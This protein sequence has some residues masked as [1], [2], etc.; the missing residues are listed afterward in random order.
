MVQKRI[1][2]HT[3]MSTPIPIHLGAFLKMLRDRHGIAQA[4]VLQHLP[5]WQQSAY[6]KVEKDTRAPTFDQLVPIYSALAQAGVQLS[7]QDRQQF[8]LLARRKIE[9]RKTRHERKADADWE[10]L[11]L[12]LAG[13]DQQPAE[14][15]NP[16]PTHASRLSRPRLVES[17]HL[18]GREEWIAS[19][20]ARL[21]DPLQKLLILQG[22]VG[23]GKSSELHRLANHFLQNISWYHVV[24]CELPSLEQ[25]VIGVD[26]A[27][28]LLLS[29]ILEVIGSPYASMP[30]AS[31]AA[32]VKYV[33][34]CLSRT[35][36]P[37][38]ILLDNAEQLLDEYGELAPVSK[39]FLTKFVQTGHRASLILATKEW[40][41]SF[42]EETQLVMS[43]TIPV[44]SKE[45][46]SQLFHRLG[47]QGIPDEHLGRVVEAVGGIPLCL[48]WVAKLVQE[49]M[50]HNDWDDFEEEADSEVMLTQLLE[51]DSLFGGPVARRLQPLLERVVK[52]LSGE[53]SSAL[54]ELAVSP[55]PLGSPALKAL[56]HDPS[57]LKELR[58]AS[59]LVAY[60]KRV[61]LLPMVAASMRS[62]MSAEQVRHAEERLIGAFTQWL[63]VGISSMRE[64]GIAVTELVC[65]LLHR[66]RL[67]AAAELILYYGWLSR[68]VGQILRLAQFVQQILSERPWE[69]TPE[70]EVEIESGGI[71]LHYYLSSYLGVHIDVSERA[72]AY[73]RILAHVI[74]G[75]VTVEPLMEV[76]LMDQIMLH[77]LYED[78]FEEAQRLYTD[79]F[80]RLEP[81]LSANAELHATLLSKQATMCSKRSNYAKM[82]GQNDE[83][84]RLREETIAIY[85]RCLNLLQIAEQQK[86]VTLLRQ[87]TLK[88]KRAT[89]LNNLAYQLNNSGRYE[90]ALKLIEQCIELK[91]Q[92]FAERDSLPAAYNEKSQLLA[93]LGQ[94]Q[95]A[96][97][98]DQLAREEVQRCAEAGDA[99]SQEE[100]WFYQVDQGR[101]YLLLGRVDEAEYLL[102]EAEPHIHPQRKVYRTIARDA[103][104][105]IEQWRAASQNAHYQIDWRWIKR[106]RQLGAYDSLWWWAQTGSFTEEEQRQWDQ[107]YTPNPDEDTK[108]QLAGLIVQSRQREL[109]AAITEG[110]EPYLHYP[111]L[112]IEAVRRRIAGMLVLDEEIIEQE[113]N[114]IVR[115]LYHG[116]IEDEVC[117]LRMIEATY[118]RSNDRF[119]KLSQQLNAVPTLE[120]MQ[121]AM[122]RVKHV[123]L[124]GMQRED[125][126]EVCQQV[127]KVLRERFALSLDLSPDAVEVENIQSGHASSL[128]TEPPMVSAQTAKRF[129]DTVLRDSGFEGWQVILD[130]NASD[131][132]IEPGLRAIFL[133]IDSIPLDEIREYFSHE[134]V[135]HVARSVAGERS[136]LGLLAVGTKGYLATEEG[137]AEYYERHVATLHRQAF[138]DSGEWLGT[139][140][141]GLA[142]G[143]IAAPQTFSVLLSFFEPFLLLYRLLWRDDEDRPTAEQRARTLALIRC[144][145][146][147]RGVPDLKR[148]GVCSTKDTAYLRGY[149][150]IKH[151]VAEDETILDRLAVGKVA[152]ELLP[153][154]HELGIKAP[155]HLLRTI[156]F[157]PALDDYILSFD[158]SVDRSSHH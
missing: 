67:L 52:R 53:A 145:R 39:Q 92:G 27:L 148:A 72:E 153:D 10:A 44:F 59:L 87:N 69:E 141:I 127:I 136:P 11:R 114:T 37:V 62:Q 118:E 109:L 58:D 93:A 26:I 149:L 112:E 31:L 147:Y 101:L 56:Y 125:T 48:E 113:P 5:G 83:T 95:E 120:E 143:A 16:R 54:R 60:P 74:A 68:H 133:P 123:I 6:S 137:I 21:Q 28:E 70:T 51:D 30:T 61:Q 45:E 91:E 35:N 128:T 99:T 41:G 102:R 116:I 140:A 108:K 71:L 42:V 90:E 38:L 129:F 23:I 24:L 66:H 94:F 144:L 119:W 1:S 98:F 84:K 4:E 139:V 115:R 64:Q 32:R 36:Q 17:R 135:G 15:P 156:A 65:L 158:G 106:Y 105:E 110:R 78:R 96:L 73:K 9:S 50:L 14:T 111:A 7:L 20:V 33:L 57:R 75:Q 8:L 142:S 81:L 122:L 86:G 63:E 55:I 138:D 46:G 152:I 79:S 76:H 34:E 132:R 49:P 25:E 154:L 40:P 121:Y 12:A 103:L 43:T 131:P 97:R 89:F 29:D 2:Y 88:K 107:K 150:Q 19:I 157:D 18:V 151:A 85:E 22:P 80:R 13:A 124:Q 130:P 126:A 104:T 3:T 77:H 100:Q 134:V 82:Q 146:T 47:L 155:Q 117:Y